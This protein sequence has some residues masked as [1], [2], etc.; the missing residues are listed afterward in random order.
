MEFLKGFVLPS[1]IFISFVV[2]FVVL[3]I[4]YLASERQNERAAIVS[5]CVAQSP[6]NQDTIDHCMARYNFI[7]GK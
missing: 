2:V 7:M 1:G 4:E 6:N 5:E 3:P